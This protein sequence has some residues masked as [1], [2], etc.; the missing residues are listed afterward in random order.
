VRIFTKTNC[1]RIFKNN[2]DS[3][4]AA[5]LGM[6]AVIAFTK[7]GGVG[8]SPDSIYYLSAS[9]SVMQGKGFYQFDDSP[10]IL[11]PL[12]YP[13]FLA[14]V[15]LVFTNHLIAIAPYM[16]AVLFGVT[17]F[18]SGVILEK[19]NHTKWL[20]W[21]LLL[22]IAI[23]PS[24]LEIYTMLWS[25]GL[26]IIEVLLFICFFEVYFKNYQLKYLMIVALITAVSFE[27]RLVGVTLM[28]TGGLLL[29]MSSTLQL[30]RK[31]KHFIIYGGIA[32]SLISIN[33][34]RNYWVATSLT[35]ARQKGETPL[36]ENIQY[37]GTV[38]SDWLPLASLTK[39]HPFW[40][41]FI[42]LVSI[43]T[44]FIFRHTKK[45]EHNAIEKIAATFT[46]VYSLFMLLSATFSKYE[47]INNRLLAPFFIPCLFTLSFYIISWLKLIKK[48]T[49]RGGLVFFIFIIGG[50]TLHQYYKIDKDMLQ[51]NKEGG[52][53]G[54][55]DDDW[56][57]SDVLAFLKKDRTIFKKGLPVYSN[58]SHAV[59]FFTGEH[60]YILPEKTHEKEMGKFNH[61][62]QLLLIWFNNEDNPALPTL[63]EIKQHQ[64]LTLMKA[65]KDGFIYQSSPK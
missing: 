22:L 6:M 49:V 25:E 31:L 12:F 18:L 37:Y 13:C 32:C 51:D 50:L 1:L 58:A 14:F 47:T 34:I 16:N 54:Y 4:L 15:Q 42:F 48:Q 5:F 63:D 38:L 43:L 9:E 39:G 61:L 36:V 59:Y 20:K 44:I 10:F 55:N 23:S 30:Q 8:I 21:V 17:I 40:L 41:G 24:L 53:G 60:L 11:F 7:Y 2:L 26:F 29:M 52:I 19:L 3:L 35:G 64:N 62:P 56:V 27:T 45:M 46:L 65:F 28:M 33:L 57:F